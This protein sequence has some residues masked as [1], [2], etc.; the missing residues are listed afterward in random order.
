MFQ[1][2][3]VEDDK[4]TA[5][6][7]KAFLKHAGYEVYLADNGISALILMDTQHVDLI[8]LDLMMPN[9]NGNEELLSEV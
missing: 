5:L 4:S 3:V 7:M 6:Y 9:M 8:I 2:L 1:V